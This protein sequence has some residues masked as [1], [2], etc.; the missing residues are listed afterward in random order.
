MIAR[1]KF[2]DQF[3]SDAVSLVLDHKHTQR[4]AAENLGI[5]VAMLGRWIREHKARLAGGTGVAST[6]PLVDKWEQKYRLLLRD[7]EILK[8]ALPLF[9]RQSA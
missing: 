6:T 1:R 5:G 2:T 3:R 7:F 9:I 8:K 4:V